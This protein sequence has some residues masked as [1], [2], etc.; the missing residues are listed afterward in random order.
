MKSRRPLIATITLFVCW[1]DSLPQDY[2]PINSQLPPVARISE[3][4]SFIFSPST[5]SSPYPITYSLVNAPKWLSIDSNSRRLFGEP[6][7]EDVPPGEVV[8]VPIKL[9]AK[10]ESGTTTTN[11]TLVVSRNPPPTVNIPL[12][13]QAKRFGPF[14]GPSSLLLHPSKPFAYTF[15]RSTFQADRAPELNYYAVTGDNAPLPSWVSFN[16]KNLSF[17]GTTPPFESLVQPPQTFDVQLVASDVFGFASV[18]LKF[19]L[20]VGIHELTSTA[21]AVALNATRGQ[22]FEYTD[23]VKAVQLDN[24]TIRPEEVKSITTSSL[25]SWLEFN[26]KTWG[27]SGTPGPTANSSNATVFL[28]DTFADT[29]NISLSINI[30]KE[31]FRQN[32]TALDVTAG[33][34]VLVDLKEYL[35]DP[36]EVDLELSNEPSDSWLELDSSSLV[37]SGTV[38]SV[39]DALDSTITI[40]ATSKVTRQ[41]EERTMAVHINTGDIATKTNALPAP[42]ASPT[43]EAHQ[44]APAV[45]VPLLLAVLL[46]LL[47]LLIAVIVVMLCRRRRNRRAGEGR[48][49]EVSAPIP[50]TFV[51]H[52]TGPE[53]GLRHTMFDI[54]SSRRRRKRKK[55]NRSA[56]TPNSESSATSFTGSLQSSTDNHRSERQ[57]VTLRSS[58]GSLA[59]GADQRRALDPVVPPLRVPTVLR[60]SGSL[61]SDTS[62]GEDEYDTDRGDSGLHLDGAG[63]E[64]SGTAYL[65]M[66]R[67]H[68]PFSIQNTPEI[69]YRTGSDCD[70]SV[71]LVREDI[72]VALSGNRDSTLSIRGMGRRVSRAWKQGTAS[73]LLEEYKRKSYQSTSSAKTGRTSLLTTGIAAEKPV[74]A[75]VISRPT[76]VHI[77]S[78]PGEA[79]QISRRVDGSSPLFGGGSIANSPRTLTPI[80]QSSPSA[81]SDIQRPPPILQTF[82]AMSR[83]SDTSWDRI[84][85]DSLGI[86]HKDLKQPPA[87]PTNVFSKAIGQT[88]DTPN[89]SNRNS[90]NLMSPDQWLRPKMDRGTEGPHHIP[91]AAPRLSLYPNVMASPATQG[92]ITTSGSISTGSPDSTRQ[93][94]P[95]HISHGDQKLNV[96]RIRKQRTGAARPLPKTKSTTP[97]PTEWP[98]PTAAPPQRPLPETPTRRPL[99]E[100]PNGAYRGGPGGAQG[101]AAAV[102]RSRSTTLSKRSHKTPASERMNDTDDGW[103]DVRPDESTSS[104]AGSIHHGSFP[105]LI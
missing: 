65:D 58:D 61:L 43:A 68:E 69:A 45:N 6:K 8:G 101:A 27:L 22:Q 5:F 37:L 84:A 19:S 54:G 96:G 71:E 67:I 64:R 63:T 7:D 23:L 28:Q 88:Q 17:T 102:A 16:P 1:A 103:E 55:S 4:F 80:A 13:A 34:S 57:L 59:S 2:F 76:I 35:W 29:V 42:T 86:A 26:N 25:P 33:D 62:I 10:D 95:R 72:G 36:S 48:V 53:N 41:K 31:L 21:S 46:P 39:Q 100:R 15:D 18:P 75:N 44:E 93:T 38:P 40:T 105:A 3:P 66:P 11:A 90:K 98:R 97:S 99:A 73:K 20:V 83:D 85:R 50:G 9:Q 56:A 30:L 94:P 82:T 104:A 81:T 91:K 14:S 77:P 74:N 12:A 70:S 79:R 60:N 32:F 47:L 87:Q 49:L 51:R 52:D 89:W 24:R 92:S 78:R